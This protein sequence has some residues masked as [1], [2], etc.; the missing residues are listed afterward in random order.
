MK[1]AKDLPAGAVVE[2]FW[3]TWVKGGISLWTNRLGDTMTD[4]EIDHLLSNGGMLTR[5]PTGT[6]KEQ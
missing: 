6:P 3:T 1:T 2:T 4:G 5:V